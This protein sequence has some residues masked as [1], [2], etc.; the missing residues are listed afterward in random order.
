MAHLNRTTEQWQQID[1]AHHMHPF[2]DYKELAKEGSII[3]TKADGVY[4]TNSDNKQFLDAMAG[5]WCV[6]VGYGRKNLAEVAYKQM[7]ELP[8]YNTFF[9]T[10]TVPA[11]SLIHI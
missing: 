10:A 11:L 5:L 3:I 1:T 7:Q 4:L 6:N 2:T 9:K 8:Y